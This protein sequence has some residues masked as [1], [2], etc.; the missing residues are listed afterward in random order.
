[1]LMQTININLVLLIIAVV[2]FAITFIFLVARK[3]YPENIKGSLEWGGFL[4]I[5]SICLPIFLLRT[6]HYGSNIFVTPLLISFAYTL[7]KLGT[8]KFLQEK[9][10]EKPLQL[11]T[12]FVGVTV[13]F[14][15]I[16]FL[17][18]DLKISILISS[19]Y[20]SA[21]IINQILLFLKKSPN[22]LK[23]IIVLGSLPLIILM[24]VSLCLILI[25]GLVHVDDFYLIYCTSVALQV[26]LM[27]I[28]FLLA[29]TQKYNGTIDFALRH[30]YLT[31]ALNKKALYEELDREI[32]FSNRYKN[33]SAILMF[34]LNGLKQINDKLGHLA[35]DKVLI[36]FV[37]QSKLCLRESDKFGRFGGDEFLAVLPNASKEDALLVA[38]RIAKAGYL[39]NIM[40][41]VSWGVAELQSYNDSADKVI[42]RADEQLYLNKQTFKLAFN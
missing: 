20:C 32:I 8:K 12:K 30:D 23:R 7:M 29:L 36:D 9:S 33:K 34:D 5:L 38:E 10:I 6:G 4:L 17:N 28:F 26:P 14:L 40:W 41:T 2:D 39:S 16:I 3:S 24:H 15:L 18:Y 11:F 37:M 42:S 31:G 27:A 19:G 22:S 35:G 13:L 25:L 21:I 1:M